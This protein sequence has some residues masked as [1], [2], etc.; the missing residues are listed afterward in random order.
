[1]VTGAEG[2]QLTSAAD[3][4]PA[5]ARVGAEDASLRH[6]LPYRL[7]KLWGPSGYQDG[8]KSLGYFEGW[9]FKLVDAAQDRA[10]AV[11]PGI[12]MARDG[13][14]HAFVQLNRDDGATAYWR[15]P[16]EDF[17]WSRDRFEIRIGPNRFS[18]R[19]MDLDL[20]G[21][22]GTLKGAVTFGPWVPWPVTLFSPGI[23]GWYRFVP[24]MECYHGVLGLDHAVE[25]SLALDGVT[26]DFAGGRGYAEK[27]WGRSFPEAWVWLQSNHFAA[28]SGTSLTLSVAKIPFVGGWFVGQIAGL[29]HEGRLYRFATYTGAKLTRLEHGE[30][31]VAVV[32]ADR[33]HELLVEAD[34]ARPGVLASPVLGGMTGRVQESLRGRVHARLTRVADGSVVFEGDGTSVGM[35][36]MDPDSVLATAGA[37]ATS[38]RPAR[39]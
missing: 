5:R 24:F 11:I 25:G 34:G 32:M 38:G 39:D 9:Y 26:V 12:S 1:M 27:D 21:E 13:E 18:S 15:Y 7:R 4:P 23:M 30:G 36:L 31:G 6:V 28:S 10:M 37:S 16:V 19:G 3:A 35:E 14:R 29:L 17:E 20:S 22:A 2:E 8:R 33:R